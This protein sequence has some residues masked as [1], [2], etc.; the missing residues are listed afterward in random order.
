MT[1]VARARTI[2]PASNDERISTMAAVPTEAVTAALSIAGGRGVTAQAAPRAAPS[3]E[4]Q[5]AAIFTSAL[6]ITEYH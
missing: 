2:P 6:T 5:T 1:A 3:S 4:R